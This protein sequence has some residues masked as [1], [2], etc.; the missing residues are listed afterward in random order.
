M[1]NFNP[2]WY[3]QYCQSVSLY[4]GWVDCNDQLRQYYCI[5]MKGRK[6]Y[7]YIWCFVF[8]VAVT[9]AYLLCRNHTVLFVGFGQ[10]SA[11]L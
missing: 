7:K 6:Y 10:R 11:Q 1:R 9:N 5:Q 4:M 8:D 3:E 2:N